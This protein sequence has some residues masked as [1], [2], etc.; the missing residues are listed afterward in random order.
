MNKTNQEEN[1]EYSCTHENVTT[2]T[3]KRQSVQVNVY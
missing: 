3:Y 1:L 2:F